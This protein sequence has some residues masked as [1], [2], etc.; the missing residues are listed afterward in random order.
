MYSRCASHSLSWLLV[1]LL[2]EPHVLL[3]VAGVRRD[4][5]VVQLEDLVHHAVE[6]IAIVADDQHP[7]GLLG[8]VVFEPAGGVDVEV[9]A[10]LV[11][12]HDVGGGEQQLGEHQPALLAAGEC[13]EVA[14]E[15]RFREAEPGEHAFDLVI[16]FEGVVVAEQF[17]EAIEPGGEL[18]VL[19]F[20]RA[21]RQLLGD[22]LEVPL[23][24]EQFVKGRLGFLETA[25]GPSGNSASC[26]N[27]P[28]RAPACSVTLPE[29]GSSWPARMRSS[30]V[31]PAPFG[32]TKPIR[33]PAWISNETCSKSGVASYPR[34][35][36]EQDSNSMC[37]HH[38]KAS[39]VFLYER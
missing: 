14:G 18:L 5:P 37:R 22:A 33:S 26:C 30:V 8:E 7:F 1:A 31:L 13:R 36:F 11:E 20:I 39:P 32:P 25:C 10:R 2:A 6:E 4:P 28:R 34:D 15:V 38:G 16:E 12:E 19:G 9:V 27:M 29:S 17:V 24:G 3:E 21:R 23:S 35:R